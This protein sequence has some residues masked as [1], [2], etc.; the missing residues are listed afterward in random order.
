MRTSQLLPLAVL[1]AA[2]STGLAAFA[3]RAANVTTDPA[4][5]IAPIQDSD[6]YQ[7]GRFSEDQVRL[8]Q[9]LFFDK[10]L[11]GN[12]NISC[13]T[14]HH[15]AHGTSDGL[16]LSLGEGAV[17]LATKR[18]VTA[19]AP[20]LGRVPRNSQ[21]LFFVGAKEFKRLFHDG[22]I[23]TDANRNW[24]S[25]FWSPAREQL[26]AG[27]DNVLAAQAMFPVL[28]HIEM[29]GHKGENAVATA[30]AKDELD[31]PGGAWD[32]LAQR[33]RAI[34]AYVD[35]FKAAYPAIERAA[36][37]S[38]VHAANAIA[39]FETVAFR[40]DN[41]PFDKY[42]RTRDPT[43][44]SAAARRGM[45][46]FYGSAGCAA[47]HSGTFQTDQDFHA[48]A[49]PQIGPGKNDGF[50]RSYW[51]ATGFVGR[52]EDVGRFRVTFDPADKY[53]FRT[54]SLRNVALTGP[55]GHAGAYDSLDAVIRHHADPVGALQRYDAAKAKLPRIAHVIERT[56][57][58]SKLIHR[59]VN[60]AR[61]ADYQ[62][63]DTWVLNTSALRDAIAQANELNGPALRDD[64]VA[65]LVEFLKALT[66]P[67]SRDQSH[68]IPNAVP[69]GLPVV[70]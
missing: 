23:E 18:T 29:A 40:P 51:R 55:W 28:S 34:P 16:A 65:D 33:L 48:I 39:A 19:E 9:L 41:S 56:A 49:M 66:D 61:L 68:L 60:P 25:G 1:C 21:A 37:I 57:E 4:A 5:G 38:F 27:L 26:P 17:G 63:R 69:S 58:G 52:L 15:P 42:L 10:I 43:H 6:F 11:S 32:L 45:R 8:G 62:R 2:L 67:S 53:R 59:P 31:G 22:R 54:P 64:E 3:T 35:L 12:K 13:A 30:V 14:C 44:L 70:D 20:V 46:L 50:D 7:D 24:E 47:C 36:D